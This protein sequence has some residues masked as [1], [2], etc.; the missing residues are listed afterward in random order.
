MRRD[1]HSGMTGAGSSL[2]G[3]DTVPVAFVSS[4]P[5]RGGSERFLAQLLEHLDP[6]W[7][8]TVVCL[9]DGPLADDLRARGLSVEVLSAG[10]RLPHVLAAAWRLRR[11][12]RRTGGAVVHANG[13][14][15]ALLAVGATIGTRIP[16]LWI[17]HDVI[18]DGWQARLIAARCARVIGVSAFVT[19]T[20][21]GK[22]REKVE[23][24]HLQ[25]PTPEVD[26]AEARRIVL[27]L[28][29][30]DQ[31]D[32]VVALVGRLDPFKGQADLLAC[33][34]EILRRAPRT[35]FLFVGGEDPAHPGTG[36]ALLGVAAESG[37]EHAVRFTG[38][39]ADA[40]A[41]ICGSD[42][43]VIAGGSNEWGIGQEG[44]PLVGLEALALGTAVVGYAH[45]GLPEQVGECGLLVPSGDR[46]ALTEALVDLAADQARRE[47]LAACGRELFRSRY[48]LSTLQEEL[49]DR[50]R[51][52]VSGEWS[53]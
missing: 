36:E 10:T 22:T 23:V 41:L 29:G 38:Y 2:H 39:R 1:T 50:Y 13:V 52:A 9:G 4:H 47:R 27:E 6:A 3:A 51:R 16:V 5:F 30:P 43:L 15:A 20:F 24:L 48:E 33:A 7:I 11:L 26:A 25:I 37:L 53:R 18:R 35:R 45:G 42:I 44:F 8:S 34:P 32:A 19:T 40:T 21:R 17:K 49:T 31:P 46:G 14:K 12:L 28:F